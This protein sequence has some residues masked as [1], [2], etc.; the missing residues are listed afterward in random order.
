M[1]RKDT[2]VQPVDAQDELIATLGPMTPRQKLLAVCLV[3]I[4]GWGWIAYAYQAR[5]GLAATAMTDYFSWGI[6]IINF[7]F[8]IGI[9]MAGTL[10]SA[11]LRLTGATWRAPVTRL[12]EA[13]TLF[14]LLIA[15]PM[16]I[17][18]MGR[19]DRFFYI[20]LHGRI[21]SPILWDVLSLTTYMAGSIL[22]L[23]LPMI[24]DM[25]ILRDHPEKFPAW[26]RRLYSTMA[27][28]W[29]GT[30]G[31]HAA[32]ERAILVMA[33]VILPVAVSIHTVTAW[34]FGMTLRPG[35]HTT[36]IG[37]D[38]VIG[39][40]YSGVAAVITAIAIF[41]H[42]F[43]LQ[44]HLL[45]SHFLKLANLLLVFGLIY[46]YF[47]VNEHV[48]SIYT[49]QG[50]EQ[51]LDQSTFAG[52]YRLE[53]WGMVVV[54]MV[55]PLVMLVVP[56]FRT[57]GGIVCASL[58]VNV[59]MWLKRYVIVVPT[60]ATPFMPAVTP[61][62][63][64]LSYVPTWVEWSVTIGAFSGFS[65]M[66][67]LFAKLFPIIS[68]WELKEEQDAALTQ[69]AAP[70][71][72]T[73][74][75]VRPGLL[76]GALL[77]VLGVLVMGTS[78]SAAEPTAIPAISPAQVA[79]SQPAVKVALAVVTEDGQKLIRAT[80]T[81]AGKP[82]ENATIAFSVRRSFG[83]LKLGSDTTLDD[84]TAAVKFPAGLAGNSV[85]EL[86]LIAEVKTPPNLAGTCTEF[87]SAGGTITP[88]D[89]DPFP[90]SLWS[91]RAPLPLLVVVFGLVVA[92]WSTYA[93]IVF[94]IIA[95]KKGAEA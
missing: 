49:N 38:F 10:I 24:P 43:N 13:I 59:G 9:S 69:T 80:V 64:A 72:G 34:L 19:P 57:V 29:K 36:I 31:Q 86:T 22:Y 91:P 77:A 8:F 70:S 35:W 71:S 6:Y 81:Q 33:I 54:G 20:L 3:I 28:G 65:L 76:G 12:A 17:I 73:A 56:K 14:S 18:D 51:R 60:L 68:I 89:P 46:G 90:R 58:L 15:G 88:R 30:P 42:F 63:R 79:A 44:R 48:G 93:Y 47:I 11:I 1:N 50:A 74:A 37:P 21:Q 82:L 23:Y 94:Q 27:L 2:I 85:G 66:Y 78:A 55:I 67:L 83:N 40:L 25:A 26:R 92:V 32:L 84:G 87:V 7:V 39:A 5:V 75:S 4:S 41:R 62:G 95:I 61:G 16:I 53:F 45:M 52:P